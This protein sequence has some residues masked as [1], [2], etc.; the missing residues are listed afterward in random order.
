MA[1]INI[2]M[3]LHC[4]IIFLISAMLLMN[5]GNMEKRNLWECHELNQGQLGEKWKCYLCGK[6]PPID[7]DTLEIVHV[8]RTLFTL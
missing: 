2:I 1:S 3:R 5:L 7:I 8:Q 4:P 6:P